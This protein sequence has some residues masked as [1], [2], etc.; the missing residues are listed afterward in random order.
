MRASKKDRPVVWD[1]G[2]IRYDKEGQPTFIIEKMV[3]GERYFLTLATS[4]PEKADF[5]YQKFKQNREGYRRAHEAALTGLT[6]VETSND[7]IVLDA[8]MITSLQNFL[9]KNSL[10]KK[11]SPCSPIHVA[12]AER[13]LLRWMVWLKGNDLRLVDPKVAQAWIDEQEAPEKLTKFIRVLGTWLSSKKLRWRKNENWTLE[14]ASVQGSTR[15][16]QGAKPYEAGDIEQLYRRLE[17]QIDR[18]ILRLLVYFGMHYSEIEGVANGFLRVEE[19]T[20]SPPIAACV[21]YWHKNKKW[22]PVLVDAKTLDAFRRIYSSKGIPSDKEASRKF[23]RRC[24]YLI[25]QKQKVVGTTDKHGRVLPKMGQVSRF[26]HTF[27][28]WRKLC[29]KI[30]YQGTSGLT[31]DEMTTVTGHSTATAKK[32]YDLT[33]IPTHMVVVPAKLRHPEDPEPMKQVSRSSESL[34]T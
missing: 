14:L 17:E 10:K 28:S 22:H 5:E 2:R 1:G 34:S 31:M 19:L 7:P 33:D 20:D 18:D 9:K 30:P 27:I 6:V 11:G 8:E 12:D 23:L 3:K 13:Y 16:E 29:K 26:R 25:N 15:K 4:D 32:H 21:R 24:G